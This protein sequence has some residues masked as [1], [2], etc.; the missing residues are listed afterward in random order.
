MTPS[1]ILRVCS[2]PREAVTQTTLIASSQADKGTE[3]GK[4]RLGTRY[5]RVSH[6]RWRGLGGTMEKRT[7]RIS[8]KEPTY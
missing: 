4:Q 1:L 2:T 3:G 5:S 6:L 7:Q 8:S